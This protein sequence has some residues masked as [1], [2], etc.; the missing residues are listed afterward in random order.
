MGQNCS[1][2]PA[3]EVSNKSSNRYLAIVG[4]DLTKSLRLGFFEI[5]FISISWFKSGKF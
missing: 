5:V 2:G 4:S 3:R 1:T